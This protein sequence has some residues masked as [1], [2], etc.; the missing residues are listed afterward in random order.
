MSQLE[1]DNGAALKVKIGDILPDLDGLMEEKI[2]PFTDL[3]NGYA[4]S[5]LDTGCRF[6]FLQLRGPDSYQSKGW[7]SASCGDPL[8]VC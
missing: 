8:T 2:E 6:L 3:G 1:R 5:T 7:N 4:D